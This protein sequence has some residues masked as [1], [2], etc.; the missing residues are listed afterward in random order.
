MRRKS[1]ERLL[2]VRE[3]KRLAR[4]T[5]HETL[6]HCRGDID[7]VAVRSNHAARELCREAPESLKVIREGTQ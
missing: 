2:D 1:L 6:T 3:R 5:R 7:V 4:T